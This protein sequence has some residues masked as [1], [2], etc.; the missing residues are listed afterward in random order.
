V[1]LFHLSSE[2]TR[3]IFK[4]LTNILRKT[5]FGVKPGITQTDAIP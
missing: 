4:M 3:N 2:N 5:V 1:Y